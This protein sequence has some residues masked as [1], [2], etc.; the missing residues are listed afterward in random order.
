MIGKPGRNAGM[1]VALL[2]AQG[3][4]VHAQPA[5]PAAAARQ[6]KQLLSLADGETRELYGTAFTAHGD[7]LAVLVLS[8][9]L[10][11]VAVLDGTL[12][13]GGASAA[14]GR[15]LVTPIE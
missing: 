8:S 4:A 15:V 5:P 6:D 13:G 1:L 7:V 2:A 14:P 12:A 3:G 11:S 10:V 9:D